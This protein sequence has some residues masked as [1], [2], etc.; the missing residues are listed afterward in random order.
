M[1]LRDE[2]SWTRFKRGISHDFQQGV[3]QLSPVGARALQWLGEAGKRR[4]TRLRALSW[5][6]FPLP[7]NV[8][9]LLIGTGLLL[10]II[11]KVPQGTGLG[12]VLGAWI[13]AG[14]AYLFTRRQ[15]LE[16]EQRRRRALATILLSE[17]QVLYDILKDIHHAFFLKAFHKATIEPFH[18]AMYDQAGSDRLLFQPETAQVLA[19]FYALTHTLQTELNK[20]G[21]DDHA[22]LV[23][24]QYTAEC[25]QEV[26]RQ[27]SA[28]GGV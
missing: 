15:R 19:Q 24:T 21:Q 8:V 4:L 27:L 6:A 12:P 9:F 20:L 26:M 1:R 13:G 25:I 17:I 3:H 18:T 2:S 7:L 5:H 28:E 10:L 23:R 14:L 16:E 22:L 11:I